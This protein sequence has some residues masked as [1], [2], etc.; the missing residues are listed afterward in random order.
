MVAPIS[1]ESLP[2]TC[3]KFIDPNSKIYIINNTFVND[4]YLLI[5]LYPSFSYTIIQKFYNFKRLELIIQVY[6]RFIKAKNYF[7]NK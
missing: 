3:P 4:F 6:L 2:Q 1:I 5:Y 7:Y